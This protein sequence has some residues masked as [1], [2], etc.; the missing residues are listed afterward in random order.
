ML[1]AL[2]T[3]TSL[4]PGSNPPPLLNKYVEWFTNFHFSSSWIKLSTPSDQI[5]WCCCC[6]R[7]CCCCFNF[8]R[9]LRDEIPYPIWTNMLNVVVFVNFHHFLRGQIP[10]PIWTNVECVFLKLPPLL[11]GSNTLPPLNK[12]V[13]CVFFKLPPLL[14]SNP[15]TPSEQ[16]C[17]MCFFTSTTSQGPYPIWTN[18]LNVFFNFH[19]FLRDQIPYPIWTNM[20]NAF[21]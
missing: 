11:K 7:C 4:H 12:Y 1:N 17:W 8:H 21:F 6:C 16:I 2:L 19:R 14:E 18:I 9:F 3:S 20:L 15:P 13:E 10:H 5:C